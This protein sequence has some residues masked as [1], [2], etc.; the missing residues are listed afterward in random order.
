[1]VIIAAAV[2]SRST[3]V[4]PKDAS[5]AQTR[6]LKNG[7]I[8]IYEVA[9]AK[10]PVVLHSTKI[11]E[12]WRNPTGSLPLD[13]S[14]QGVED[15]C[16]ATT[17]T[18]KKR[19]LRI[20]AQSKKHGSRFV[21]FRNKNKQKTE[22]LTISGDLDNTE[23][24]SGFLS[25]MHDK[26][27][28]RYWFGPIEDVCHELLGDIV[29]FERLFFYRSQQLIPDVKPAP[30]LWASGPN[31]TAQLHYDTSHNFHTLMYGSKHFTI[32]PPA[33]WPEVS[34]YPSVHPAKRQLQKGAD[35]PETNAVHI[36]LHVGE[37]LYIPP[38]WFHEVRSGHKG[39]L[40]VTVIS[41]SEIEIMSSMYI[42]QPLDVALESMDTNRPGDAKINTAFPNNKKNA[43][44]RISSQLL[45]TLI[46]TMFEQTNRTSVN[47]KK[48]F[49]SALCKAR[50]SRILSQTDTTCSYNPRNLCFGAPTLFAK[51][52]SL[53]G[54]GSLE[55]SRQII[56]QYT[57]DKVS[58]AIKAIPGSK[59]VI[60]V[61]LGDVIE[62]IVSW[63]IGP[64]HVPCYV[65][66]CISAD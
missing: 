10:K 52:N 29:G 39:A 62:R 44:L 33:T 21:M 11:S 63:A 17:E 55:N 4:K 22:V 3:E 16:R 45:R 5:N 46:N 27:E 2:Y 23:L 20:F 53:N 61:L 64:A 49:F 7:R 6:F 13:W 12:R 25:D 54:K 38:F 34:L 48:A 24:R 58:R 32:F 31:T 15:R 56:A 36:D 14:P 9:A 28:Y 59:E 41:P 51:T 40:S 65:T 19:N 30:T 37:I 35:L 42:M 50:Y 43:R 1:M 26:E 18:P 60:E 66:H 57:S 47:D 8:L